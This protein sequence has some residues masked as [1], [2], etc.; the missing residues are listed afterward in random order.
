MTILIKGG[1][2]VG[3]TGPYA[4]DVLI[5]GETIAAVFAP[6]RGPDG[7]EVID[8]TGKYVIPG[9]IDG[10]THMEMPFGGTS[11]SDTFETGTT[12]AAWGGTTTIIDFVVQRTGERVQDGLA[13]W[14]R[15]AGGNC[16]TLY[17]PGSTESSPLRKSRKL[18]PAASM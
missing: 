3:P 7:P 10:H 4:A 15:K 16:A 14:H 11:A 17:S 13:D 12:A 9:G 6:G 5:D 18:R 8:A 1:T 2:V